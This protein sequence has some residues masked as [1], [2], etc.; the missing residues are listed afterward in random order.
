MHITRAHLEV[1]GKL[2][3]HLFLVLLKFYWNPLHFSH[4]CITCI[5]PQYS[6]ISLTRTTYTD[7]FNRTFDLGVQLS[8]ALDFYCLGVQKE[9]NLA[10]NILL[11]LSWICLVLQLSTPPNV[12]LCNQQRDFKLFTSFEM[13]ISPL[14]LRDLK[15]VARTKHCP[16]VWQIWCIFLVS[17]AQLKWM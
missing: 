3:D 16:S 12:H 6:N 17:N 1:Q 14:R 8:V 2:L 7:T 5:L 13:T 11:Y 10:H 4:L 15:S 9:C